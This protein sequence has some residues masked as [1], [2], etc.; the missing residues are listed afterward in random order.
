MSG[1][2]AVDCEC[3]RYE[4]SKEE[5]DAICGINESFLGSKDGSLDAQ[6]MLRYE[7]SMRDLMKKIIPMNL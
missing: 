3:E 1:E 7:T 2:H 5:L 4:I 6:S